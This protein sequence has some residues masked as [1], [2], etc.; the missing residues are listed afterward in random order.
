MNSTTCEEEA[1]S[2]RRLPCSFDPASSDREG[3]FDISKEAIRKIC[4]SLC[5]N[6][7]QT[8]IGVD[9]TYRSL[10]SLVIRAALPRKHCEIIKINALDVGRGQQKRARG[11]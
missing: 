1:P 2:R 7:A 11:F 9:R 4:I 3:R 10:V 6:F 8:E 5:Q